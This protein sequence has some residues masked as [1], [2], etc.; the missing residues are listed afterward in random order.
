[1]AFTPEKP[2]RK[3]KPYQQSPMRIVIASV[4]LLGIALMGLIFFMPSNPI[5]S[6][7]MVVGVLEERVVVSQSTPIARDITSIA[8]A[9]D[10][11]QFAIS[12]WDAG[13]SY[14][15]IRSMDQANS[16]FSD[17]LR[18]DMEERI[19]TTLHYRANGQEIAAFSQN[20]SLL[21]FLDAGT[22]EELRRIENI[23]HVA[24][25]P[26]DRYMVANRAS[27]DLASN[28]VLTLNMDTGAQL[29]SYTMP[30]GA[31]VFLLAISPTA[32][33]VAMAMYDGM[34]Y[35]VGLLDTD[36][37]TLLPTRYD[38]MVPAFWLGFTPD[39]ESVVF[40]TDEGLSMRDLNS[41]EQRMWPVQEVG[42]VQSVAFS[43]PWM[44]LSGDLP[45]QGPGLWVQRWQMT[46]ILQ[47]D[48]NYYSPILLGR[49]DHTVMG[50]A[51][52]ADGRYLLSAGRDG[53]VRMFDMETLSLISEL[54]V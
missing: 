5:S 30:E 25:S 44:A 39:G 6:E 26:D 47:P 24:F 18:L 21:I 28:E 38:V 46:D 15:E 49:P 4:L 1:M 37:A 29:T 9:P 23:S 8:L 33:R 53:S 50:L 19:I 2:K 51:F 32:R 22:G 12:I 11:M 43:G 54:R 45:A 36:T 14:I 7:S 16:L 17:V 3:G 34:N 20:N 35:V 31:Y 40:S 13:R 27:A 52:S 10:G 42:W 41:L 48:E